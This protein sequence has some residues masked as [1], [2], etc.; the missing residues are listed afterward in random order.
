MVSE[1]LKI[2]PHI[3]PL[4]NAMICIA[5]Q[6][7]QIANIIENIT[8]SFRKRSNRQSLFCDYRMFVDL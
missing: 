5:K 6:H 1:N 4:Y 7:R 2:L 8:T 3:V